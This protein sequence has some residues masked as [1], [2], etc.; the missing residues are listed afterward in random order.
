MAGSSPNIS[1]L[2]SHVVDDRRLPPKIMTAG[3]AVHAIRRTRNVTS[4]MTAQAQ[5]SVTA[6]VSR[7]T[8]SS[9][10]A[11]GREIDEAAASYGSVD[12]SAIALLDVVERL[13]VRRHDRLRQRDVS[14]LLADLLPLIERV[15]NHLLQRRRHARFVVLLV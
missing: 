15:A 10:A 9:P 11:G 2:V 12:E 1:R 4:T 3:R 6:R 8:I 5:V 7:S 14:H 13:E